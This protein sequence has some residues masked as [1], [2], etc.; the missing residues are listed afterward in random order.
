MAWWPFNG[1]LFWLHLK[2][3]WLVD[4]AQTIRW[5]VTSGLRLVAG[6]VA[7]KF[8]AD[9]VTDGTWAAVGDGLIA[10]I[11]GGMS[12]W[13]SIAGRKKLLATEPKG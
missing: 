5:L 11:V 3:M 2:R 7:I 13:S 9:A 10:V 12:I 8:G 1:F 4:K 6:Y